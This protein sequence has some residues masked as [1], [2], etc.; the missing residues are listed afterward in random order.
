M[1]KQSGVLAI[2]GRVFMA[3]GLL[4]LMG[5]AAMLI[6][7]LREDRLAGQ[8][9]AEVLTRL[10]TINSAPAETPKDNN[11][12]EH[13]ADAAGNDSTQ[14]SVGSAEN[15]P[16]IPDYVKNPD[17]E[18][19]VENIDGLDYIG[20]VEAPSIELSLPVVSQ[21]SY[22]ALKSAP[23][24]YSGSAYKDDMVV[25]AHNYSTHFGRVKDLLPGDTV[26]FTD[27]DGNVFTYT[28]VE[29]E[30]LSPTAIEEMVTGDW[31]LTLFTCT[32]GAKLRIAARC[33]RVD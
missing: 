32:K 14:L 31:D 10:E 30:T 19:P 22:A 5:S 8:Q 28:V 16:Y 12:P 4:L 7:N 24:R 25:L 11:T 9:A 21:W 23:C 17:M 15:T 29:L 18:M 13:I 27:M 1:S 26:Y 20:I 3:V 6:H 2:I 33:E